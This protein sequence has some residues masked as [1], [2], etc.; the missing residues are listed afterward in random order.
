MELLKAVVP[1]LHRMAYMFNSS[2]PTATA[3]TLV[4]VQ[5]AAAALSLRVQPLAVDVGS[6]DAV[7]RAFADA[8]NWPADAVFVGGALVFQ[9]ARITDLAAQSHLPAIYPYRE[10]V[11]AGGLMSYGASLRSTHRHA[12]AYVD[13][14]LRGA[15]PA[16]LPVEQLTTLEFVVN[17]KALQELGLTIP[18]DVAAQVTEWVA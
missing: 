5:D 8:I 16:D 13:K 12:A 11:D 6:A 17:V 14:I 7:T 10:F 1:G 9:R 2:N 3:L 15:T 4:R 18:L